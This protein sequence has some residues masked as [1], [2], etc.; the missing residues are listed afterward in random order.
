MCQQPCT[1]GEGQVQNIFS[2]SAIFPLFFPSFYFFL[3]SCQHGIW[4]I[5]IFLF[6]KVDTELALGFLLLGSD[7]LEGQMTLKEGIKIVNK[8]VKGKKKRGQNGK[9]KKE[10]LNGN[11]YA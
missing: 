8:I 5:Y 7:E 3:P 4:V 9:F 1:S 10:L 2:C 11:K 6:C